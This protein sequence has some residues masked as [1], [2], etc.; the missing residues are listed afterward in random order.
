MLQTRLIAPAENA[1]PAPL[2]IKRLLSHDLPRSRWL[3]IALLLVV[4]GL[5]FAPFLFP[6]SKALGVA[7]AQFMG[8]VEAESRKNTPAKKR[9]P[10]PPAKSAWVKHWTRVLP[11]AWRASLSGWTGCARNARRTTP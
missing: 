3:A 10:K 2:L 6:G 8:E 9:A 1:H 11:N 4:L 7:V 5:A